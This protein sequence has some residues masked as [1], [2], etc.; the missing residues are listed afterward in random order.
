M[1]NFRRDPPA[2]YDDRYHDPYTSR[3]R[4][5]YSRGYED[6]YY[7]PDDIYMRDNR[8]RALTPNHFTN[9]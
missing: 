8:R 7:S 6:D 2:L 1:R 4:D 9:N 5:M 3:P